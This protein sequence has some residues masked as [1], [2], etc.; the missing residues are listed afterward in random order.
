MIKMFLWHYVID[1]AI[2]AFFDNVSANFVVRKEIQVGDIIEVYLEEKPI[3]VR[4][5]ELYG[6]NPVVMI[7]NFRCTCDMLIYRGHVIYI[8]LYK[9]SPDGLTHWVANSFGDYDMSV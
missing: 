8:V 2:H 4:V 6:N 9:I 3:I 1:N 5:I 7:D